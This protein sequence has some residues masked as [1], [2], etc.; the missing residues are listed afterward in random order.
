[1]HWFAPA[2]GPFNTAVA[3]YANVKE[4]PAYLD[5]PT[6][7]T[8]D[9]LYWNNR[10]VAGLSDPQ[11][12]ESYEAIQ[13]YRLNTMAQGYQSLRETDAALEK[14]AAEGKANLDDMDDPTV[15]AELERANQALVDSRANADP[16]PARHRARP[17]HGHDEERLQHERPLIARPLRPRAQPPMPDWAGPAPRHSLATARG[18]PFC[19]HGS[20]AFAA[21]S[22]PSPCNT[23]LFSCK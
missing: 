14:L 3:L 19:I 16:R 2:S 8:T 22:L 13:G 17:A 18:R 21:H 7:V 4:L 20:F 12:F 11:F 1:M 6:E 15:I 5:T 10:L 9:S 23:G